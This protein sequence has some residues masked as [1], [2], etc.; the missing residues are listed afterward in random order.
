MCNIG[1][2][3]GVLW[4][5]PFSSEMKE[6]DLVETQKWSKLN[7]RPFEVSRHKEIALANLLSGIGRCLSLRPSP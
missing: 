2:G 4:R 3:E 1:S 6:E 7:Y 5:S